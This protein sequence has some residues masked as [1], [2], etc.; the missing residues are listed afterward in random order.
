MN[1]TIIRIKIN[2]NRNNYQLKK[3][4]IL[5]KKEKKKKKNAPQRKIT[6][7]FVWHLIKVDTEKYSNS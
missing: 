7:L 6:E 2:E 4:C 5:G 1:F 3:L